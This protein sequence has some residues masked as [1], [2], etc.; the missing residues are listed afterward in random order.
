LKPDFREVARRFNFADAHQLR[1]VLTEGGVLLAWFGAL[2][3]DPWRASDRRALQLLVPPLRRRLIIERHL[4]E[5][6][7]SVRLLGS[8]LESIPQPAFLLHGQSVVLANA[9]G[10]DLL[11]RQRRETTQDLVDHA[12]GR[13]SDRFDLT[14]HVAAGTPTY[15]LAVAK[16]RAPEGLRLDL[17]AARWGLTERQRLVLELLVSGL[18]NKAIAASLRVSESTVEFHVGALLDKVG[19][20]SRSELSARF[21]TTS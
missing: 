7:T 19:C 9:A 17:A 11:H 2:R 6:L 8:A 16:A 5:G 20:D 14:R 12:L 10:R 4:R 15:V 21:W 3:R 1:T 13:A 18:S